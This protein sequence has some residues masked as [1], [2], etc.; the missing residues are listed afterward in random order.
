MI[1]RAKLERHVIV[2]KDYESTNLIPVER[3]NILQEAVLYEAIGTTIDE[4]SIR[5]KN[6]IFEGDIDRYIFDFYQR[7]CIDK[8]RFSEYELHN[9]GGTK[10]SCMCC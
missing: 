7:N 3:S 6:I 4:F 8:N 5:Y 9:G 10:T 1:D 2:K